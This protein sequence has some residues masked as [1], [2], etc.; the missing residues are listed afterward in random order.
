MGP[1]AG[2]AGKGKGPAASQ[3][4]LVFGNGDRVLDKGVWERLHTPVGRG[5]RQAGWAGRS[6]FPIMRAAGDWPLLQ[7]NLTAAQSASARQALTLAG[8]NA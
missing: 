5:R 8:L 4:G 3:R 2:G 6:V 1:K 7:M